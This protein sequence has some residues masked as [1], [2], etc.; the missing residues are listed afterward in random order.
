MSRLSEKFGNIKVLAW[1]VV[2]W[3]SVCIAA[4]FTTTSTQFYVLAIVVG[5]VMGGIQSLSR[6]TYSK[7][8]PQDI[9]DS[10]SFF[11]FYDVTEKIAIVGGMFSFGL[12][13]DMTN[14]MRN[15]T[16]VLCIYFVVGLA[17]LISLLSYE[18]KNKFADN[19]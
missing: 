5:M 12:V 18:R 13:D 1:V 14:S 4:Y 15:S 17:L 6:S 10:A 16:L 11:S 2:I 7:M 9:T 19:L 3:I 8:I